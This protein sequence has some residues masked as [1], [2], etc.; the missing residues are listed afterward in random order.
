MAVP[1][2]GPLTFNAIATEFDGTKPY[3]LSQ[4]YRNGGLVPG[5]NTSVSTSGAIAFSM[6]YGAVNEI[7]VTLANSTNQDAGTLFGANWASSVPKQLIIPSGIVVGSSNGSSA[8]VL[9][10]GMAG[11][12]TVN[13]D[14]GIHGTGGSGD[15][16]AG[17][18]ALLVNQASGI[19]VNVSASGQIFGGGGGGGAAARSR[20]GERRHLGAWT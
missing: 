5:N 1:S 13:V 20:A 10:S 18:D 14:G 8:L 16:G 15:S 12:L 7:V 2:S 9:P 11:T 3:S 6:F 4:Y 19:T 17:G